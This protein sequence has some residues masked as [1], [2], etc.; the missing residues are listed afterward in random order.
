MIHVLINELLERGILTNRVNLFAN[1][2]AEGSENEDSDEKAEI[3]K[4]I[5]AAADKLD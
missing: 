5:A 4:E 2:V 1:Q 3:M